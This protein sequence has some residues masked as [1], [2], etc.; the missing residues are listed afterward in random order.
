MK[1]DAIWFKTLDFLICCYWQ[2]GIFHLVRMQIGL[3]QACP[4]YEQPPLQENSCLE[5]YG[6]KV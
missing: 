2:R 4:L 3:T 1:Q 5:L 6:L